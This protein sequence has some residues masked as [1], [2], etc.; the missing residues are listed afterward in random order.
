MLPGDWFTICSNNSSFTLSGPNTTQ[1]ECRFCL[2]FSI[3]GY[4]KLNLT[5]SFA[6]CAV[7]LPP[8]VSCFFQVATCYES[9]SACFLPISRLFRCLLFTSAPFSVW[10]Y[11]SM[12]KST[13][14]LCSKFMYSYDTSNMFCSEPELSQSIESVYLRKVGFVP[15]PSDHACTFLS[16]R[17]FKWKDVQLQQ[18]I[19]CLV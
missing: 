1:L 2:L 10:F 4:L 16:P 14:L 5:M 8:L 18:E 13:S 3:Y 12:V 9:T 17:K 6:F 11:L 15:Q 19:T 7:F